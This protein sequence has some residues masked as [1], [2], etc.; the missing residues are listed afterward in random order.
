M[1]RQSHTRTLAALAR[2]PA[3]YS[4]FAANEDHSAPGRQHSG[5]TPQCRMP[6]AADAYGRARLRA[7]GSVK[8]NNDSAQHPA[9]FLAQSR[10][11]ALTPGPATPRGVV[12]VPTLWGRTAPIVPTRLSRAARQ[13]R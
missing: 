7:I 2:E 4:D 9:L 10:A 3:L 11:C 1:S 13:R 12:L 5:G 6:Q 8:R